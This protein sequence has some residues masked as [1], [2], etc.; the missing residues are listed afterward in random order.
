VR[1]SVSN[2]KADV[3]RSLVLSTIRTALEV[4]EAGLKGI[5]IPGGRS[6]PSDPAQDH[7][8]TVSHIQLLYG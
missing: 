2:R 8:D 1:L 3:E 4:A 6:D 5:G 7:G